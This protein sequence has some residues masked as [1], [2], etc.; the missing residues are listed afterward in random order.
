MGYSL[1]ISNRNLYMGSQL[2]N[3]QGLVCCD[4]AAVPSRFRC[5]SAAVLLRFCRG[6]AAVPLPFRRGSAQTSGRSAGCNFP[7]TQADLLGTPPESAADPKNCGGFTADP[8]K[9]AAKPWTF[10]SQKKPKKL[11]SL[12]KESESVCCGLVFILTDFFG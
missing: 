11:A 5:S 12:P 3:R 10:W 2:L 6:S 9:Y 1:R 4:S 7:Q 8:N